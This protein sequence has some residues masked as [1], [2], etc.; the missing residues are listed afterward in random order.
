MRLQ[1]FVLRSGTM[2]RYDP[3]MG[4]EGETERGAR[5]G[6]VCSPDFVFDPRMGTTAK[7]SKEW[8]GELAQFEN[9]RQRRRVSTTLADGSIS[10]RDAISILNQLTSCSD[11][12]DELLNAEACG[13]IDTLGDWQKCH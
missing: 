10:P 12:D 2:A 7:V 4:K 1:N 11:K 8:N 5:P 3:R 6:R 13:Y 9:L